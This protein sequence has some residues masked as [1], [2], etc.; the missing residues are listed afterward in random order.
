[1]SAERYVSLAEVKDL[2]LQESEDRELN[3]DQK[4]SLEHAKMLA[5]VSKDKADEMME[6]LRKLD[7]VSDAMA[8]K[9][10]DIVPLYPEDIRVLFAKER[11]ILEK[12]H[13]DQIL[14]TV[15]KYI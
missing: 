3:N 4:V 8:C 1:M 2:L 5:K 7:F 15:E 10:A 12:S 14:E 11:L 9:I 13:V 6:E